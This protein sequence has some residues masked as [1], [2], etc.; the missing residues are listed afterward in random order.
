MEAKHNRKVN[1]RYETILENCGYSRV[2]CN[3]KINH[4]QNKVIYQNKVIHIFLGTI[5]SIVS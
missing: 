4:V 3:S 2:Y 1:S 5:Y